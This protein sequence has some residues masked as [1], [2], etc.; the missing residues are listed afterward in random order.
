MDCGSFTARPCRAA[1]HPVFQNLIL[2]HDELRGFHG[3]QDFARL[4]GLPDVR[5]DAGEMNLRPVSSGHRRECE[6]LVPGRDGFLGLKRPR[7]EVRHGGI[8]REEVFKIQLASLLNRAITFGT[9]R[10]R[11][12]R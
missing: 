1:G 4:V 6:R 5:V 9:T 11:P 3:F 2:Q 10:S 12:M 7:G 8:G